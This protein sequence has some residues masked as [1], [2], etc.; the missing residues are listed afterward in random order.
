MFGDHFLFLERGIQYKTCNMHQILQTGVKLNRVFRHDPSSTLHPSLINA[1]LKVKSLNCW[2]HS[3]ALFS[4]ARGCSLWRPAMDISTVWQIYKG[5]WEITVNTAGTMTHS[6]DGPLYWGK[7]FPACPACPCPCPIKKRELSPEPSPAFP[8]LIILMH[9]V[10]HGAYLHT[11]RFGEH[12]SF[13]EVHTVLS[14][15]V[16]LC[17]PALSLKTG[18]YG[19][20]SVHKASI[21]V[22]YI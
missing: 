20:I 15:T 9:W 10:P 1:Y 6:K 3:A 4:H 22:L 12:T 11:S 14:V 2:F 8:G 21:F 13:S 17:P 5:Q 16:D 19:F 18:Y 7:P